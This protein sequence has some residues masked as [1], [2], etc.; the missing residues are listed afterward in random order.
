MCFKGPSQEIS[1]FRKSNNSENPSFETSQ[2]SH[3]YHWLIFLPT[4]HPSFDTEQSNENEHV[5]GGFL[6][7]LLGSWGASCS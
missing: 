4:V 2:T 6:K 3:L 5:T 1:I 7:L